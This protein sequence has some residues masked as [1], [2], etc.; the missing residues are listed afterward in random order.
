MVSEEE[1]LALPCKLI[2][3]NN[4]KKQEKK[5]KALGHRYVTMTSTARYFC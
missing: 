3:D 1:E 5:T 2:C 4:K